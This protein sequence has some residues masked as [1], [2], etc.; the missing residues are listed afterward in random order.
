MPVL[1]ARTAFKRSSLIRKSATLPRSALHKQ[2]PFSR[3]TVKAAR[4]RLT[5][6]V[7]QQKAKKCDLQVVTTVAPVWTLGLKPPVFLPSVCGFE[8]INLTLRKPRRELHF[9]GSQRPSGCP[10][11]S[12]SVPLTLPSI[13]SDKPKFQVLDRKKYSPRKRQSHRRE[14]PP[15]KQNPSKA[16]WLP[17]RDRKTAT[18]VGVAASD[19]ASTL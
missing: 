9:R 4:P 3:L 16:A 7:S 18:T 12:L 1:E 17:E 5:S 10:A 13:K 2:A 15:E 14:G 19:C 11:P 8:V 6:R